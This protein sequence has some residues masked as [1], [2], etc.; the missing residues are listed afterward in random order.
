MAMSNGIG[1]VLKETKKDPIVTMDAVKKAGFT[2]L[3]DYL[4]DKRG[5][6]RRDGKAAERT[7]EFMAKAKPA[8]VNNAPANQSS[9][10]VAGLNAA[11]IEDTSP[12][13]M[14]DKPAKR[15]EVSTINRSIANRRS[16]TA[17]KSD[18]GNVA[19]NNKKIENTSPKKMAQAD[20]EKA[21]AADKA[22]AKTK[23]AKADMEAM[24]GRMS[25]RREEKSGFKLFPKMAKGGSVRGDGCAVKGKTKGAMR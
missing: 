24:K 10:R 1:S 23:K 12:K 6:K 7:E 14:A 18:A 16:D 22:A 19:F 21:A 15:T 3:R 9:K 20:K 4:N 5:L 2:N 25:A 13:K 17:A 8:A 11:R